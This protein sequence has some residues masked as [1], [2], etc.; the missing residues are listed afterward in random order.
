MAATKSEPSAPVA[1]APIQKS[2]DVM[3]RYLVGVTQDCPMDGITVPTLVTRKKGGSGP[4]QDEDVIVLKEGAINFPKYTSKLQVNAQGLAALSAQEAGGTVDLFDDEVVAIKQWIADRS[5]LWESKGDAKGGEKR[6]AI[7]KN[8]GPDALRRS[9]REEVVGN[10]V[11]L[12]TYM[13]MGPVSG[14]TMAD[15]DG[16]LTPPTLLEQRK[17]KGK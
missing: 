4:D 2:S 12:E 17:A 11:P 6:V 1:E 9:R 3:I 10:V 7:I 13:Y 8:A 15:R 14:I 16:Q 5:I